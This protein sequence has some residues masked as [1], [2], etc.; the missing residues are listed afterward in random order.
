MIRRLLA[1]LALAAA[2]LTM[3]L[4]TGASASAVADPAPI[5]VVNPAPEAED[6]PDSGEA[7]IRWI[8]AARCISGG[9]TPVR[10]LPRWGYCRGGLYHGRIVRF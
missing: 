7:I 4:A 1:G 3:P 8:S 5:E 6:T 9:G 10:V 2:A